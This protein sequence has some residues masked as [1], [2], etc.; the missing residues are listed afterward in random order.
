MS[1]ENKIKKHV[2]KIQDLDV[3]VTHLKAKVFCLKSQLFVVKF[4]HNN[5]FGYGYGAGLKRLRVF[6]LVNPPMDLRSLNL[7]ALKPN[8][9]SRQHLNK[10]RTDSIPNAFLLNCQM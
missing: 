4:V 1:S 6:L 7:K 10:I 3:V 9:I 5:A 2:A 8:P